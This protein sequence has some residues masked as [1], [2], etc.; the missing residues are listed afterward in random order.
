MY[1][2]VLQRQPSLEVLYHL[3]SANI[4]T[5]KYVLER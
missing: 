2:A 4:L 3:H 5:L 1:F